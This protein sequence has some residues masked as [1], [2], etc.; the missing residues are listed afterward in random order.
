MVM[1]VPESEA[2]FL[3]VCRACDTDTGLATESVC[4]PSQGLFCIDQR[5]AIPNAAID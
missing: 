3:S 2:S 4:I 1:L 5:A